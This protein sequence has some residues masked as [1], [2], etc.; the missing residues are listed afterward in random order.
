MDATEGRTAKD[1]PVAVDILI[2]PRASHRFL[3][4]NAGDGEGVNA[5]GVG[6]GSHA[7]LDGVVDDVHGE[8]IPRQAF[9]I[10]VVHPAEQ[11]M[12]P[13]DTM[14]VQVA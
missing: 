6:R 12:K 4:V 10:Q 1:L 7:A 5:T 3:W 11:G 13:R 2:E 8:V 9:A 14:G